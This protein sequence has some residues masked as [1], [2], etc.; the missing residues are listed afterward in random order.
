MPIAAAASVRA[1]CRYFGRNVPHIWPR[2]QF[3]S[4]ISYRIPICRVPINL[5]RGCVFAE[6]TLTLPRGWITKIVKTSPTGG[7]LRMGGLQ[8]KNPSERYRLNT[9]HV[10]LMRQWRVGKVYRKQNDWDD[11]KKVDDCV[12][13]MAHGPSRA[14]LFEDK[15][16]TG[17]CAVANISC[18]QGIACKDAPIPFF[19]T[20]LPTGHRPTET[21]RIKYSIH[22]GVHKYAIHA[23]WTKQGINDT[24]WMQGIQLCCMCNSSLRA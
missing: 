3:L 12:P 15:T 16:C 10:R 11:K 13:T 21:V 1:Y 5:L 20:I 6:K 23:L 7:H 19:V 18:T 2:L 17:T 4:L 24:I 8:A 9:V 22:P 14:Q